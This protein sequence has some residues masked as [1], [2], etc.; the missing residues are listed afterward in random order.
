MKK[1]VILLFVTT[2]IFAACSKDDSS[3][4][5]NTGTNPT[6]PDTGYRYKYTINTTDFSMASFAGATAF[7]P[8]TQSNYLIIAASPN[9]TGKTYPNS[10]FRIYANSDGTWPKSY[11]LND[12]DSKNYFQFLT[13]HDNSTN[14]DV[15]YDSR[16][17]EPNDTNG[18]TLTISKL[19]YRAGGDVEG[20]FSGI[21]QKMDN[22]GVSI[23]FT[24]GRFKVKVAS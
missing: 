20:T 24:K 1:L 4:S 8:N 14:T 21:L 15:G 5:T 2:I 18:V 9:S 11:K 23:K 22:P 17:T 10:V 3:S 13:S 16:N 12:M 6:A 7:D 19:E